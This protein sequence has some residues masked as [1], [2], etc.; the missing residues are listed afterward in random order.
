M[1]VASSAVSDEKKWVGKFK[2]IIKTTRPEH[3]TK[4]KAWKRQWKIYITLF[5]HCITVITGKVV[6][7][8]KSLIISAVLALHT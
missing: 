8:V 5:F 2:N 7:V 3:E 1:A 4:Q 6:I